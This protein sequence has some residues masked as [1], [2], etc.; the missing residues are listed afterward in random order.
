MQNVIRKREK[1]RE[2]RLRSDGCVLFWDWSFSRVVGRT[3]GGSSDGS[4]GNKPA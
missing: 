4:T 1:A 2:A 3:G